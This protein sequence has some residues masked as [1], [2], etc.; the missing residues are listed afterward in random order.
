MI[1]SVTEILS[2]SQYQENMKR[3]KGRPAMKKKTGKILVWMAIAVCAISLIR[4]GTGSRLPIDRNN[5]PPRGE[6]HLE[7][8]DNTPAGGSILN[9]LA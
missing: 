1:A 5:N 4:F 9:S 6:D 7:Y 8:A 2:Q 3:V